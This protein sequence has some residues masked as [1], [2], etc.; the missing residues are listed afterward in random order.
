MS[1]NTSSSYG[2]KDYRL[3]MMLVG[4]IRQLERRDVSESER[5]RLAAEIL[6]IKAE[7]GLD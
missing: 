3:E 1:E 6:R 5:K 2:C 7:M 4:L